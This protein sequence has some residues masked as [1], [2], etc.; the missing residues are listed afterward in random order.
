[1]CNTF[2][3]TLKVVGLRGAYVRVP[4]LVLWF[5]SSD[6]PGADEVSGVGVMVACYCCS[7][8]RWRW[9]DSLWAILTRLWLHSMSCCTFKVLFGDFSLQSHRH[10]LQKLTT[11]LVDMYCRVT[12]LHTTYFSLTMYLAMKL[13]VSNPYPEVNQWS[14]QI[15]ALRSWCSMLA[16]VPKKF[17]PTPGPS[18]HKNGCKM[19]HI[20]HWH[21]CSSSYGYYVSCSL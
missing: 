8:W 17:V 5:W 12:S 11:V 15:V 19:T 4:L 3:W 20:S 18:L 21:C 7:S 9:S 13:Q 14:A 16:K 10:D 1:M 2:L 6:I